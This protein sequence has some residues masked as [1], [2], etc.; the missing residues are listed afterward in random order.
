MYYGLQGCINS[1]EEESELPPRVYYYVQFVKTERGD[2]IALNPLTTDDKCIHHPTLATCY[3][4]AQSVLKVGFALAKKV[5][6]RRRWAG[7]G[8]KYYAHGGC[9]GWL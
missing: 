9:L 8:I 4:L 3:Q 2:N 7:L 6:D 5:W 1:K